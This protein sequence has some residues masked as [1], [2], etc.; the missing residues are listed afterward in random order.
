MHERTRQSDPTHEKNWRKRQIQIEYKF[1]LIELLF[2]YWPFG[3]IDSK[4]EF[5]SF[6]FVPF[7]R[8]TNV[9]DA[10]SLDSIIVY[11]Y[12]IRN[13]LFNGK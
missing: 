5:K 8:D 13:E 10:R 4:R 6:S 2:I 12:Q 1:F 7:E 3:A 9:A 11:F